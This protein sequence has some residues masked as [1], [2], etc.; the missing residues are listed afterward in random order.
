MVFVSTLIVSLTAVKEIPIVLNREEKMPLL[1]NHGNEIL[2][3]PEELVIADD[4]VINELLE[5]EEKEANQKNNGHDEDEDDDENDEDQPVTLTMLYSSVI[6]VIEQVGK[7]TNK[8]GF[9][10]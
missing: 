4:T 8:F 9:Y 3:L 10:F 7:K 2:E 6:R 5:E 1:G